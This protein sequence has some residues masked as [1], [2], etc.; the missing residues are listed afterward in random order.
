MASSRLSR[1]FSEEQRLFLVDLA[2]THNDIENKGYSS[3]CLA[4]KDEA[5]K[6]ITAEFKAKYPADI[7]EK[8][9][10]GLWKRI[11]EKAKKYIDRQRRDMSKTGGG[12]SENEINP[13]SEEASAVLGDSILPLR[14]RYDHDAGLTDVEEPNTSQYLDTK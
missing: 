8:V 14:N 3:N 11:K 6:K 4:K 7:D 12:E 2:K 1:N 9:L 13:V 10:K 5:W